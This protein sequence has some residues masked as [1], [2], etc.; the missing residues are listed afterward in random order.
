MSVHIITKSG[1]SALSDEQRK[2]LIGKMKT[3]YFKEFFRQ[4]LISEAQLEFLLNEKKEEHPKSA[5]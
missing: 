1:S 2:E 4:G 3:A 5:A